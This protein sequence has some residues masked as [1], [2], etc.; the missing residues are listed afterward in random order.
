[1]ERDEFGREIRY[2]RRVRLYGRDYSTPTGY[3]RQWHFDIVAPWGERHSL[4]YTLTRVRAEIREM[5]AAGAVVTGGKVHE[6]ER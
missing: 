3:Q 4:T 5:L 1:M 6:P 2:Y